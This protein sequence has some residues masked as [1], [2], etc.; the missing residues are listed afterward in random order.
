M[1]NTGVK[2]WLSLAIVYL[3]FTYWYTNTDGPLTASEVSSY[4]EKYADKATAK[5]LE[6]LVS[7]M[8]SDQGNQFIMVNLLDMNPTPA[9]SPMFNADMNGMSADQLLGHYMEHMY[10]AL[11][12]RAS[13]PLFFGVAVAP[14]LDII[15]IEDARYWTQGALVRYRSRR[16][17]LE[18]ASN[19]DFD[20]RHAYKLTALTKTIAFP[21]DVR[22][23]L[24]DPRLLLAM[25]LL[26]LGLIIDRVL[27]R[28]R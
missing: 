6:A 28:Y 1:I 17:M 16:D 5:Q 26:I 18:I 25:L 12:K 9:S 20:E 27:L 11:F 13:H 19:P 10:P 2:L 24:A 21:V 4:S 3:V 15:G 14:A 22:L 7:F 8:Q 23:S